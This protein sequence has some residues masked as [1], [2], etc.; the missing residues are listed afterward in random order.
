MAELLVEIH[1][2]LVA[3][4]VPEGEHPFPW[5][6]SVM[7]YLMD[8]DGTSGEMYGDGEEF[9][10]GYLFF[11]AGAPESDLLNLAR[12]VADLPGVPAGVYAT[13]TDTDAD[14]GEG[15]RVDLE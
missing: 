12:R 1:V 10:D 14:M 8:L 6:D 5:I 13:V 7:G 3:S 2:P 4:P 9:G 11:L 15:R